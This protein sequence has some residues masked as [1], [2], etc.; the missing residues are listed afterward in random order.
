M[1]I[2][3]SQHDDLRVYGL[4]QALRTVVPSTFFWDGKKLPLFD[5]MQEQKPDIVIYHDG[6]ATDRGIELA[7]QEYPNTKFLY[8]QFMPTLSVAEPDLT[9]AMSDLVAN[10]ADIKLDYATNLVDMDNGEKKP[11]FNTD[12]VVITDYIDSNDEFQMLALRAI[13]H[14]FPTK[15][16]GRNRLPIP[17][18]LGQLRPEDY[19]HAFASAKVF[20]SFDIER[21]ND[22]CLNECTPVIFS[23]KNNEEYNFRSINEMLDKCE[24]A[25]AGEELMDNGVTLAR[26]STYHHFLSE[27]FDKLGMK[28]QEKQTNMRIYEY[29][30]H[31]S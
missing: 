29:D 13:S 26:N 2:F 12:V 17:N 27:M 23:T 31:Y 20:V 21:M 4:A 24:R 9:I 28:D 15:I 16:Y 3:I 22:A 7:K 5:L 30:R 18:Y 25:I 11:K 8:M 6:D 14:K 10:S 1:K 19:K